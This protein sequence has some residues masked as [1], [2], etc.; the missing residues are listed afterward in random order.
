MYGC[1]HF[2]EEETEVGGR[3]I[4]QDL[5]ARKQQNQSL[6]LGVTES[7]LQILSIMEHIYPFNLDSK[8]RPRSFKVNVKQDIVLQTLCTKKGRNKY[9]NQGFLL[10]LSGNEPDLASMR[11]QVRSLA[12]LSGL[13]IWHCYEVWCRSQMW[14]GSHLAKTVA[15]AS[16]CSFNLTPSLR[17]SICCR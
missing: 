5:I 6:N 4:I 1:F 2:T 10:Q 13:R 3:C 16:R 9:Q 14:L 17:T 7:Q 8:I 11:M 15:Q 12:W